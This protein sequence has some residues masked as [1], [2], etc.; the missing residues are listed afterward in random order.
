MA[1]PELKLTTKMLKVN[2]LKVQQVDSKSSYKVTMKGVDN[3]FKSMEKMLA[4]IPDECRSSQR[5]FK[6]DKKAATAKNFFKA[7]APTV[8]HQLDK[9]DWVIDGVGLWTMLLQLAEYSFDGLYKYHHSTPQKFAGSLISFFKKHK[10]TIKES[11]ELTEN[12]KIKTNKHYKITT[13]GV[14]ASISAMEVILKSLPNEVKTFD[15]FEYNEKAS[16]KGYFKSYKN[17]EKKLDKQSWVLDGLSFNS[18]LNSITD[19]CIVGQTRLPPKVWDVFTTQL[20]KLFK[21]AKV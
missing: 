10:L 4:V 11:I 1:R 17:M 6:F 5:P 8:K 14:S 19:Y 16:A 12:A 3:A 18:L 15:K 7:F 13:K 9:N 21:V 2:G 20:I